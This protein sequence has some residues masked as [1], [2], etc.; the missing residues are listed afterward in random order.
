[1][2]LEQF[3]IFMSAHSVGGGAEDFHQDVFVGA[4]SLHGLPQLLDGVDDG[5]VQHGED[6]LLKVS[7]QLAL[8]YIHQLLSRRNR[9]Y[10]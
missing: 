6:G 5:Q 8:Q 9:I 1:M 7:G 10:L 4:R 3:F 2:K